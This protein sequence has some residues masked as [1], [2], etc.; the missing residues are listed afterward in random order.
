M[1]QLMLCFENMLITKDRF[2]GRVSV[3]S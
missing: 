3:K 2:K 1:I